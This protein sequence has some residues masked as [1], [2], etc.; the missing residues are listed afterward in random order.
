LSKVYIVNNSGHDFSPA[1]DFGELVIMSEGS[2]DK[3]Q[4][5]A[6]LRQF[7]PFLDLSEQED[8]IVPSGPSIMNA[9]AC[10]YFAA[11]HGRLNL[12][13]W[14]LAHN[15]HD[16]YVHRKVIFPERKVLEDVR[17]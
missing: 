17:K 2:V 8:Y 3:F 11:M 14:R 15:G 5:T 6:M 10:S 4:I 9:I 16:R 12:L 7:G 1:E 13:I